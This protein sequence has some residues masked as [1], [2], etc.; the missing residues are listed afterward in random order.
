MTCRFC[1][2]PISKASRT[3]ICQ[4]KACQAVKRQMER[5]YAECK[6]NAADVPWLQKESGAK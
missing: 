6:L 1:A 5:W 3:G 2:K 4:D